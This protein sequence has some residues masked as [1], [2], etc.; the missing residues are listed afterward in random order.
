MSPRTRRATT[1]CHRAPPAALVAIG[2][3]LCCLPLAVRGCWTPPG[4]SAADVARSRRARPA[5][6]SFSCTKMES[7]EQF[8]AFWKAAQ[9]DQVWTSCATH[10]WLK[11]VAETSGAGAQQL[12][13]ADIGCNRAYFSGLALD[14]VVPIG[15]GSASHTMKMYNSH[16]EYAHYPDNCGVCNDCNETVNASPILGPRT[17][18]IH[19]IEPSEIHI[20]NLIHMRNAL[21]GRPGAPLALRGEHGAAK[22]AVRFFVRHLAMSNYT[23]TATFPKGCYVETCNLD[24][25]AGQPGEKLNTTVNITTVDHYAFGSRTK[26]FDVLKIDTEGQ[27]PAVL[28]GAYE[29]LRDHR[30]KVVAFEYNS[31]GLWKLQKDG[32]GAS[33]QQCVNYLEDL[34]YACY[35]DGRPTL[36]RITGCWDP[37]YEIRYWS[38]IVCA[39]MGSEMEL[40]MHTNSFLAQHHLK[41][42]AEGAQKWD[43]QEVWYKPKKVQIK[44]R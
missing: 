6:R 27:D 32:S 12:V 37:R 7:D 25:F 3:L 9:D 35:W 8:D 4:R 22:Q 26:C 21:Y 30:A 40:E 41:G 2:A 13:I 17:V 14:Y 15:K 42:Y 23:G 20:D 24:L 39:V 1:A 10:S 19:C 44:L 18:D 29:T 38:N 33:L 16:L 11:A 31:M 28:A 5:A 34:G 43:K 36:T